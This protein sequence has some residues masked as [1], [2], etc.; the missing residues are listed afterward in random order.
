MSIKIYFY[1]ILILLFTPIASMAG[2]CDYPDQRDSRGRRCGGRA[3][4]VIPGGRLGGDGK[5]QDSYGR[6]RVWGRNNDPYDSPVYKPT[7]QNPG[8]DLFDRKN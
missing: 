1:M 3:A 4:S 5:Y 7:L 6:D 2:S 8:N